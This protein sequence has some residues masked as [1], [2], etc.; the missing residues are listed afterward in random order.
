[1][2]ERKWS[3]AALEWLREYAGS[4]DE[5]ALLLAFEAGERAGVQRLRRLREAALP[6]WHHAPDPGDD[7]SYRVTLDRLGK[8]LAEVADA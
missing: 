4:I 8:V 1:M 7:E 3:P 6:L 2:P 5:T